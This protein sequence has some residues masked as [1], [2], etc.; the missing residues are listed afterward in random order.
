MKKT[1]LLA[2]ILPTEW[3]IIIMAVGLPFVLVPLMMGRL[4]YVVAREGVT[5]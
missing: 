1:S 5:A 2:N 3:I 4:V